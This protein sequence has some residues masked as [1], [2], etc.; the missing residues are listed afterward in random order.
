MQRLN[1]DLASPKLAFANPSIATIDWYAWVAGILSIAS[2]DPI[3]YEGLH[4][5]NVL[6]TIAS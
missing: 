6:T 3:Y 5:A 4:K 2:L 1:K